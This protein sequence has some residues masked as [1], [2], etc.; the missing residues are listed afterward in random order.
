MAAWL[1]DAHDDRASLQSEH[2]DSPQEVPDIS[3]TVSDLPPRS[4]LLRSPAS[5]EAPGPAQEPD[6]SGRI[7][8]PAACGRPL[9][10][11]IHFEPKWIN[12]RTM[13]NA[14]RMMITHSRTSMRRVEA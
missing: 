8:P 7:R 14:M 2:P 3:R 9:A 13:E 5:P 12:S 6:G 11:L 4:H 1:R 10:E